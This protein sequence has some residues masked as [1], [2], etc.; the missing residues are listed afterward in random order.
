VPPPEVPVPETA[1]APNLAS[2]ALLPVQPVDS[3]GVVPVPFPIPLTVIGPLFARTSAYS[4][5]TPQPSPPLQEV[6]VLP[7]PVRVIPPPGLVARI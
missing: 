1:Q 7:K 5:S 2:D 6:E 4:R 3:P